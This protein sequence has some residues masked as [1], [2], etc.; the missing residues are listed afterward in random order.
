MLPLLEAQAQ[1]SLGHEGAGLPYLLVFADRGSIANAETFES[2]GLHG[3]PTAQIPV[4]W[5]PRAAQHILRAIER[6]PV[7]PGAVFIEGADLLVE[8][9]NGRRDLFDA[10][11]DNAT[12]RAQ[13]IKPQLMLV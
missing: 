13:W 12:S 9:P 1:G 2:L 3:L 5:G 6:Q 7:L 4:C 11:S 8:D 10:R